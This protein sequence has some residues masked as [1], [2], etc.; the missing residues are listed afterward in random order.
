MKQSLIFVNTE[1]FW[2][3]SNAVAELLPRLT[4]VQCRAFRDQKVGF[5]YNLPA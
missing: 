5:R 2:Q 3:K 1:F 4:K